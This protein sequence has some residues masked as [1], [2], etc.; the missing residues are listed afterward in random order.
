VKLVLTRWRKFEF[1][2]ELKKIAQALKNG[3]QII[4]RNRIGIFATY[5]RMYLQGFMN[6]WIRKPNGHLKGS[7]IKGNIYLDGLRIY[8]DI[9]PAATECRRCCCRTYETITA[10]FFHQKT[11]LTAIRTAPFIEEVP[12]GN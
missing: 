6:K 12:W 8:T 1:I 11:P 9:D 5:F 4:I 7:V 10:E 2:S 3:Y